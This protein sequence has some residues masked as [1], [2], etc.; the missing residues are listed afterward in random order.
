MKRIIVVLFFTPL[1]S[2][3]QTTKQDSL[4]MPFQHFIGRWEGTSEG[5][6]GKG[7]YER[8]YQFILNKRFIEVKNKSVYPPSKENPKGEIHEDIGYISYDKARKTF[9]LR[10]FHMEGFVNQYKI[11]S[12]SP[13]RKTIVFLSESMENIPSGWRAKETYHFMVEGEFAESF[14][15]ASPGKDFE[16]Y[17]K[18]TLR[19]VN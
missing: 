17:S 10:Q 5:Q 18:A 8:S 11:E 14:E 19:S 3:A 1:F 16:M 15:M 12:V 4:W 13:D 2:L 7:R 9:V 6:P